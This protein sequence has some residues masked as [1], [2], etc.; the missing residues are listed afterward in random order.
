MYDPNT[1]SNGVSAVR[2]LLSTH[3]RAI[4]RL[5]SRRSGRA[6]LKRTTEED[7][8]HDV[9]A[10]ALTQAETFN[11]TNDKAFLR[12]MS[13][14]ARR[15]IGNA[16]RDRLSR[17]GALRITRSKSSSP[18]IPEDSLSSREPSPSSVVGRQE[19]RSAVHSALARL[20]PIHRQV[21]TLFSLERR[22]LT[23][24]ANQLGLTKSATCHR[25]SRAAEALRAQLP[26]P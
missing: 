11:Y 13:T 4:R 21:I 22:P 1:P 6:V 19:N 24:V 9:V 3:D 12:W 10:E 2:S 8:F 26:Q 7:L 17:N 20:S 18:G 5:I 23:D 14:L 25:I 15:I 16:A